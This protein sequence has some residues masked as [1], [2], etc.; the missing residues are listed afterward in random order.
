M[1]RRVASSQAE[2]VAGTE[3][4]FTDADFQQIANLVHSNTGIRMPSY[5]SAMVYS[6]LAKRLRALGLA[7]FREYCRLV[8]DGDGEERQQMLSALTT[9][10][11]SFFRENYHFEHLARKVLPPLLQAARDGGRVRIWSAGCSSGE[12]PY[13]I[14]ITIL[15]LMQDAHRYD[16]KVLATDISTTVL[17]KATNGIY[18]ERALANVPSDQKRRWFEPAKAQDG[19]PCMLVGETLRSMVAFR[20]LNLMHDWPMKG[21]FQAIFCRNVVIYFEEETRDRVWGRFIPLLPVGG[22]LYIGHSER[23]G[24]PATSYLTQEEFTTYRRIGTTA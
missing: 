20:Q 5:K 3:F 2:P 18:A 23:L 22:Y 17:E 6:R 21:T 19:E 14:A 9:N 7:S 12:E 13:S 11:T 15:S 24:P 4:A 8:T 10:L 1:S 16:I